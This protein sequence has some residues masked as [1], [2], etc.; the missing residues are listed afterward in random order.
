MA[1]AALLFGALPRLRRRSRSRDALALAAGVAILANTRPY[2]GGV[3]SAGAALALALHYAG[4]RRPPLA[5]TARRVILPAL[6][7]LLPVAGWMLVYNHAVT[8]D[9]WRLPYQTYEAT[10]SVN[11]LFLWQAPK[12]APVYRHAVFADYYLGWVL[13][14]VAAQQS[15]LEVLRRKGSLLWF[16]LAPALAIPLLVLAAVERSRKFALPAALLALCAVAP[17]AIPGSHPHYFAPAAPLL[18]LLAV[19]GLRH[20]RLLGGRRRRAGRVAV[21]VVVAAQLGLLLFGFW[22]LANRPPPERAWADARARIRAS[23]EGSGERHLVLVRYGNRHSP[24][25]EWVY[26]EADIDAAPVVWARDL[27]D[28]ANRDLVAYFEDRRKWILMADANPPE[29]VAVGTTGSTRD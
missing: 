15:L 24:H 3:A 11:P 2:E 5:V 7:L 9:A 25:E 12:P 27:G 19:Q 6:A 17:L 16:F 23:L 21:A 13:D 26:N 14:Q 22:L 1:G 8:G 20:L 18:F 28:D 10:Y 29:L 4:P